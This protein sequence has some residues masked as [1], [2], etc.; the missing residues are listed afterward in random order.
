VTAFASHRR[1]AV[2]QLLHVSATGFAQ[3]PEL[4]FRHGDPG[5]TLV[6]SGPGPSAKFGGEAFADL[7]AAGL[8]GLHHVVQGGTV[9]EAAEL[10]AFCITSEV[11]LVVA[12]GGG[13]V[14]DTVKY[15]AARTRTPVMA[16]PTTLAHDGISSPVASLTDAH[17]VKRSLRAVMPSGVIVDTSVIA[18][19][20]R[21]TS[22]AGLGDLISNLLAISESAARPGL[23]IEDLDDP[24]SIDVLAKGLVMSG[25]AMATAGT[26]RPCSG[27]EH[28][29]S[30]ALDQTLGSRAA[31]HGEQVA[32]G[33]L[34][35]GVAHG[36]YLPQ[37]RGLFA[38]VGLPRHPREVGITYDE[39]RAAVQLAPSMRPERYTIL[40]TM[41]LSH[42]VID[43]LLA[44]AFV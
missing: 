42:R 22:R 38:R 14:I 34:V 29:I 41:S 25:L 19:S 9:K 33:C 20:P 2:P 3:L 24:T 31:L 15:A 36:Q 43:D 21:R 4:L 35:A 23:D 11:D 1:L 27:A 32:L 7:T 8:T 39:M 6:V 10:A 17:G 26:S 16:V 28:L 37:I 30:H 44:E 5:Q 13:R 18:S 40:S 12:V